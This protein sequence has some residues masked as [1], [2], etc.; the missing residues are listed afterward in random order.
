LKFTRESPAASSV[1][2]VTANEIVIGDTSWCAPIAV[3]PD[4][5]LESWLAPA[6]ENLSIRDLAPL[7]ECGAEIIVIGTGRRQLLPHRELMFA[8]ARQGVGLE[9][10]DT[11]A[12][13]RTF[14]VLLGEGRPVA[15]V[16]YVGAE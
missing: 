2:R 16:L 11:A 4:G 1:R 15:A 8:M 3:T 5:V 9:M 10:M 13:A 14:N 6:V 7:L 12:A